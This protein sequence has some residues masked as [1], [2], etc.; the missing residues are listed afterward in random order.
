MMNQLHFQQQLITIA[1]ALN[2]SNIHWGVGASVLL[3]LY[4]LTKVP[5]DIDIIVAKKDLE[6]ADYILS[7]RGSKTIREK[8]TIYKTDFFYEYLID[9][10]EIDLMSGFKIKTTNGVF[11]YLFDEQSTPSSILIEG[12]KIPLMTLEDWFVL[13]QLIPNKENKV[14]LIQSYFKT[15]KI[16]HLSLF[17]RMLDNDV[18]PDSVKKNIRNIMIYK[19]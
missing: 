1:E 16:E 14:T 12:T 19:G 7:Q 17:D 10:V 4:S 6:K 2:T 11:E 3:S 9:G 5:N 8:T 13:Y 15:N 18:L